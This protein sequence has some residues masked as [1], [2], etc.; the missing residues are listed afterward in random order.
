MAY[1]PDPPRLM[2]IAPALSAENVA[3]D[4][5]I[6]LTFDRPVVPAASRGFDPIIFW[7]Y[8]DASQSVSYVT[9][10]FNDPNQVSFSGNTITI[11]PAADLFGG[12]RYDVKILP[13]ELKDL[14][15]NYFPFVGEAE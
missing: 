6:V 7:A 12:R 5:N 10:D 1:P 14:A 2:T 8:D 13:S 3:P 15:G 11:N 9:I 4:A